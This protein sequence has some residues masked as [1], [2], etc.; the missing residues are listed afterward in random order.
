[1]STSHSEPDEE[2]CKHQNDALT[3]PFECVRTQSPDFGSQKRRMSRE[4]FSGPCDTGHSKPACFDV[5]VRNCDGA[6]VAIGPARHLA[7]NSVISAGVRHHHCRAQF[8]LREIREG[9]RHQDYRSF[10]RCAHAAS[11]SGRFQSSAS[12]LSLSN[13][14]SRVGGAGSSSRMVTKARRGHGSSTCSASLTVPCSSTTASTV[15]IITAFYRR[16]GGVEPPEIAGFLKDGNGRTK[17]GNRNRKNRNGRAQSLLEIDDGGRRGN[18]RQGQSAGWGD[19]S[20]ASRRVA[21]GSIGTRHA[22]AKSFA[23]PKGRIAIA[24]RLAASR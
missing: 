9:E 18:H 14:G 24:G 19:P 16:L 22:V 23:V 2:S 6:L 17:D 8:R 21:T 3:N 10:C 4:Q 1:M 15:L 7:E 13:E 12:D 5:L 20:K 11:S